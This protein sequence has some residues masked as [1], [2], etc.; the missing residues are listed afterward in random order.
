MPSSH[1][2]MVSSYTNVDTINQKHR[3]IGSN[4]IEKEKPQNSQI[5]ESYL[6]WDHK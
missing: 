6:I 1:P 5:L 3:I 4:Y 2:Q